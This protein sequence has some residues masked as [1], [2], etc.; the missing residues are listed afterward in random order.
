MT[1]LRLRA[2]LGAAALVAAASVLT[3]IT[4]AQAA[5]AWAPASTAKIHPGVQTITAGG[6]CT[7]NF[8]FFDSSNNVYIGQA[9]HC[10]TTSGSTVTNGCQA[11]SLGLNTAV[12]VG[13]A[14]RSGKLVYSS[15]LAMKAANEPVTSV[16]CQFNDF[17]LVQLDPADYA[18][19]NPSIPFWGGPV[20]LDTTGAG[21]DSKVYTYGNSSL[22]LGISQ[23]SP[24]VGICTN[25][26]TGTSWSH[27]V[28]TVTPGIPG[29]SGSAFL[30][31]YGQALGDLVTLSADGSNNVSDM[32]HE[33]TYLKAHSSFTTLQL[34]IGTEPFS[35]VGPL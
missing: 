18:K 9:A 7:A 20:A 22:R 17:A 23:L 15:W 35:S 2:G 27:R 3:G 21:T 34:A 24:H 26:D 10:A 33:L 30:D 14:S 31:Q 32:N 25:G 16:Q 6:Q 29:D 19:V 5:P 11:G 12:S 28:Y 8:V 4:P 1:N 13:G